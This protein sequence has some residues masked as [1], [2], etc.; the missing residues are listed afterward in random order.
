MFSKFIEKWPFEYKNDHISKLK[1]GKLIFHSFQHIPHLSCKYD[2]FWNFDTIFIEKHFVHLTKKYYWWGAWPPTSP[3]GDALLGPH[4][5]GLGTLASLVSVWIRFAKIS[6]V[7][8]IYEV[9]YIKI[10]H[11]SKSK[12]CTKKSNWKIIFRYIKKYIK[13][14]FDT[15]LFSHRH[16]RQ[17]RRSPILPQVG[18]PPSRQTD[19]RTPHDGQLPLHELKTL[20]RKSGGTWNFALNFRT[21]MKL[22]YVY[23][24]FVDTG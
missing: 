12:I 8:C 14:S 11:I 4:A 7:F 6:Q 20:R 2:H 15:Q 3:T 21:T 1:I 23:S 10:D 24:V 9:T 22:C 18:L 5:F 16:Q 19:L 13:S 17:S